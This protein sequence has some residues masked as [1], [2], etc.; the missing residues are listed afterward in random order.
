MR[1]PVCVCAYVFVCVCV[2]V[3][4]SGAHTLSTHSSLALA[5]AS[6]LPAFGRVHNAHTLLS[7]TRT[8]L[9]R[10]HANSS[11][12]SIPHPPIPTKQ[13]CS[14]VDKLWESFNAMVALDD[15]EVYRWSAHYTHTRLSHTRT[16]THARTHAHAHFF[17]IYVNSRTSLSFLETPLIALSS[18]P[19]YLKQFCSVVDKLWESFNAMVS[20]DDPEVFS[21]TLL[22]WF[23]QYCGPDALRQTF[24]TSL[25]SLGSALFHEDS[26]R[27]VRPS[28]YPSLSRLSLPLPL[29]P[30]LSLSLNVQLSGS[31]S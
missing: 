26:Q 8:R 9:S 1:V 12:S 16:R 6:L 17:I 25:Q 14:V 2:C 3:C 15:P 20:L 28:L 31:A 13:F 22:A 29:P 21:A 27:K 24:L 19:Q 11:H 18:I 30:S 5:C 10:A 4:D 7:H 23:E